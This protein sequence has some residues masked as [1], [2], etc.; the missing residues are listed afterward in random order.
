MPQTLIV[1]VKRRRTALREVFNGV[2]LAPAAEECR[3]L[4][5]EFDCSLRLCIMSIA[6]CGW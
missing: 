1:V 2:A 3:Q 4:I 5:S 6:T